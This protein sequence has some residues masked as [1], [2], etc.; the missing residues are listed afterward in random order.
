M[1]I[2]SVKI[3]IYKGTYEINPIAI[4]DFDTIKGLLKFRDK[5]DKFG[6]LKQNYN[7][8]QAGDLETI[9]EELVCLYLTLDNY[10]EK[11]KFN[12]KQIKILNLYQDGNTEN[13]IASILDTKQQNI[14][15]IIN[16]CVNQIQDYSKEEWLNKYILWN[17][18]KTTDSWKKCTKCKEFLPVTEKHFKYDTTNKRFKSR[19]RQCDN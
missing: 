10:I 17:K 3:D 1:I 6:E 14:N 4:S 5:I 12:E 11:C 16:T 2:G 15:D 19:C 7:M 9:N 13:D 18:K 8:N